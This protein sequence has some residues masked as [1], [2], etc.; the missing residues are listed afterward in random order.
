MI[1][2]LNIQYQVAGADVGEAVFEKM[3]VAFERAGDELKDWDKHLFPKLTPVFEAEMEKQFESEGSGQSGSWAELTEPYGTWKEQHFPGR[4][5]LVREGGMYA[6]LTQSSSPFARRV[7]SGDEYDFG[8][9]GLAYPSF[10]Q[11]GTERMTDRPLFDFSSDFQRDLQ[12]AS[13][14]A[15]RDAV[16]DSGLNEFVEGP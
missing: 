10:H 3:T 6:A 2:G 16:R 8:T 7:W 15:A 9:L 14:E 13:L 11:V 1:V 12:A 5:I 4:P